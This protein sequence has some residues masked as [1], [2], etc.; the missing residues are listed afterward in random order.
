MVSWLPTAENNRNYSF[1]RFILNIEEK[2]QGWRLRIFS[3]V[4]VKED[5]V[6]VRGS[7]GNLRVG[8]E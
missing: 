1:C 4:G 5:G 2:S 3:K 6:R 7:K 8:G